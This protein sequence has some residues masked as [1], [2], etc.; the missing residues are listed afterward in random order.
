MSVKSF[1]IYEEYYELITL[2]DEEE[3][4]DL[5]MAIIEYMF[6][7]KKPTLNDKQTKIF[8]NLKRPL[9]IA[10]NNSKRS[11]G[12]GAPKGNQNATKNKPKT[13][14]NQTENKPNSNQMDNQ[15]QTHQ[16]VNVI[17][18]VNVYVNKLIEYIESNLGITINGTNL[19][20]IENL[21]DDYDLEILMYAVDKTIASGHRTLNYFFGIV[22]N[23]KQDGFKT[24]EEIKQQD[25]R[26]EK[27]E[28][29]WKKYE[30]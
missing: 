13:N 3:Q 20:K 18:N 28:E 30:N 24:L 15:K 21:F 22:K 23:W 17:V 19:E 10:K 5:I 16:D 6:K 4:K 29:W 12:N 8:N 7:D 2:L 9:D 26:K 27:K 14:Q 25:G 1:T 11:S